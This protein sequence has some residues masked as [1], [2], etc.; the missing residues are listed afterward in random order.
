MC[1]SRF[2]Y[3]IFPSLQ[4]RIN[5]MDV[6]CNHIEEQILERQIQQETSSQGG[7]VSSESLEYSS[8]AEE[9]SRLIEERERIMMSSDSLQPI[10]NVFGLQLQL[11]HNIQEDTKVVTMAID[12]VGEQEELEGLL[13]DV[14]VCVCVFPVSAALCSI[15]TY[16][17]SVC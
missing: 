11:V 15:Y 13:E 6:D 10:L 9:K 2:F 7:V 14:Q 17:Y 5:Q 1:L 4:E 12:F 8:T 3:E 16:R